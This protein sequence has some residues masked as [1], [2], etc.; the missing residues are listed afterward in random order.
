M[1]L[2]TFLVEAVFISLSGVMAPGPMTAVAMG[3]GSD[4]PHTGALLAVGHGIIEFPLMVGIL[5]GFGV[6]LSRDG[7]KAGIALVGGLFLLGMAIGMFRGIK[8]ADARVATTL[9]SPVV[10]GIALSAG[11]PYF[12]VWWATV[13]A[14]LVTRSIELGLLGFV[15]FALLHWMCDLVWLEALSFLSSKGQRVFGRA[16][17]R[18]AFALCGGMLLFFGG[19]FLFDG[20]RSVLS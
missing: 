13:G 16:F 1:P 8:R 10:A 11:N 6:L 9:R 19:K 15:L 4:Y 3:K 2:L 20:I 7:V 18:G 12:L 5:Y 17:Q 14:T